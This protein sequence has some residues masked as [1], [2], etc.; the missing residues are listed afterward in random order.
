MTMEQRVEQTYDASQIQVLEGLEAVRKRPGMY[1]G[2]TGPKGLHHLVWEIVDNS[3]DEALAGYCTNIDV[4]IGKDNSITV[5]DNGRGIPVDIH[6]ATGRPAVEVI[7]TVLHAGG[8]F[9]G[10]G[11][12]VS[13]GLHGVGASVVNALSEWLEVY[14]YRDG[15][16]HYQRYER[17]E[18]C[19][20]LQVIGETDRTGTTTRFKPD[21]EIFTETTEFDYETL[22]TRLREL[23]FL[24]RGLKITL[25]DERVD[26]RKNEYVYEGGIRSYVRHLNRTREVLHEEPIYIAGERDG[27]AVEIALQ[28]ND[29]YTSNIYSFVNN[30]HTHEGGT[31][32]SGF[33]MA[34]TRIIND[35]AR[36]QQIFKENDA[37]LTGEDVR[38]GLTAIVSIKHPSPQFEGQTKTKLGNSDARTVTDAVFSEQFE[39][40]LL[41]NPTIA[42]KIVEKGMMAARARLAAKKARE[43]TRR[44]SALEISN[45]PG[46]LADCSSRDPSISELYVVEGDSAGGS[47]K[48]G[49]DRHFQAI[50]PLRGKI[51]NVEK[52]RLDKILSNNEVRAIITALGTGI[53]EE[54]DISKARYHKV[55]IMTDADVDGAHIRTL[56]LTFFYRYMREL[57]EH[58]YIYIAQ[59]PLYKI[60]QGKQVRYAYNDRQL[61]KILAELPDQPKPTIQRYKGLGEMNPEQLWETTMNPETRTLL[62]VSLQDAIDADE[63]F[64]ILMGDKVEPRRQFIEENARYVKNLD[65]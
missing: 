34:L 45:L 59:P 64:E 9:G 58:G 39:T 32:E 62:Q 40:F 51:L 37:N 14:V 46:K 26:S 35:Y 61:E 42:R 36:K 16:I 44:K 27:I 60:E 24:N 3:I 55:I 1:I 6:E 41:E 7:M 4:T 2:S 57:I 19:T 63:T 8:K 38:E 47:A 48:Q 33:K 54:F 23:A 43:L 30:I 15:K 50:L 65:I 28:Y 29:G 25:T 5:A 13:G 52:A 10:G 11:Y 49:R 18:P 21:P 56:L 12:K 53:G 22:A 31:H 20:D 17:G